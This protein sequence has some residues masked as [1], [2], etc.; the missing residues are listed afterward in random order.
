MEVLCDELAKWIKEFGLMTIS[1]HQHVETWITR[2]EA[3]MS[4]ESYSPFF[5]LAISSDEEPQTILAIRP[6]SVE[7]LRTFTENAPS[8]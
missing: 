7:P 6:C 5:D 1:T 4:K 3:L 8:G 2:Q